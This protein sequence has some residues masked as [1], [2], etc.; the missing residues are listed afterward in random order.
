MATARTILCI[1]SYFKGNRFFQGARQAGCRVML[2][3]VAKLLGAEWAREHID[4]V[5]AMPAL[6]QPRAVINAVAYLMRTRPIDRIV[7]LDDFDVE[8][9]AHLRE[10]FRLPGIGDSTARHFRDKL[11]MRV[12]AHE[13][14]V[15]VPAFTPLFH[16]NEVRRFLAAV[17]PAERATL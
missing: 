6:D 4:E 9:A 3:T 10:H 7:A 1:S 13:C 8:L 15:P 16:H 17:P 5:F 11:A 12:K 14:G 2:L